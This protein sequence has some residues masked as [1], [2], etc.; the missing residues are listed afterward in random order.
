[1]DDFRVPGFVVEHQLDGSASG[2]LYAA[3]EE[4]TG[5]P[6][7]LKRLRLDGRVDRERIKQ[8][9]AA[10]ARLSHPHLLPLLGL[11]ETADG[12]VLVL[13]RADGGSLAQ[14]IEQRQVLTPGE[15]VTAC[16]P[17]AQALEVIHR[18]G[19]VHGDVIPEQMLFAIDGRPML[20]GLG[21]SSLV[22][23][24]PGNPWAD[25]EYLAPEVARGHP[26][27][28]ASDVYGLAAV[29]VVALLGSTQAARQLTQYG[30]DPKTAAVLNDA[31]DPNPARRPS[32]TDL[33]D[34]LFALAA[35]EPV[36]LPDEFE[37]AMTDQGGYVEPLVPPDPVPPAVPFGTAEQ[38]SSAPAASLPPLSPP[39]MP[40]GAP[41]ALPAGPPPTLPPVAPAARS[42]DLADTPVP[43]PLGLDDTGERPGRRSRRTHRGPAVDDSA[44]DTGSTT[45]QIPEAP[46]TSERAGRKGDKSG[47]PDRPAAKPDGGGRRSKR[48]V[49]RV[50]LAA[51]LIGPVI[52]GLVWLGPK[53]IDFVSGSGSTGASDAA[54]TMSAEEAR[55]EAAA[56]CGAAP[57]PS[58]P[59]PDPADWQTVVADLYDIRAQAFA[60]LD[61]SLLC[62]V[63][64]PT[65]NGL[66]SDLQQL[67]TYK[68]AGVKVEGMTFNVES[69][70]LVGKEGTRVFL[71]ISD[72]VP[73]YTVVAKDGTVLSEVDGV[74]T[75][76]WRAELIPAPDGKSW[77]FG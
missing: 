4:S 72:S 41:P 75:A 7:A 53:L 50:L 14:I 29:A 38:L 37:E 5:R 39:A 74:E 28:A 70:Q 69:V 51:L 16:A 32:A 15:V 43:A 40:S 10:L 68:D 2:A 42:S 55:Q 35:P 59:P 76:S 67:N 21:M 44:G 57:A 6:V 58:E 31:L 54:A 71:E 25:P 8:Q 23:A 52:A 30:V 22:G 65:S 60:E 49:R 24:A 11:A 77:L 3:Y 18:R 47:R 12:V 19:L 45:Q 73:A 26:P 56:L 66:V 48:P 36:L 27:T 13:D 63:Y 17:I 61:A 46:A 62:Q 34:A 64:A 1:M 33:V 9:A 20:A